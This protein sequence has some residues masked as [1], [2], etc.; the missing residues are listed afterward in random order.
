MA[1]IIFNGKTY[2]ALDE[3]STEE[4][5]AYEQIANMLVDKN[6]NGI[7]DF[8]E[9]DIIKNVTSFYNAASSINV[10]GN[11]YNN[12]DELPPD[13]QSKVQ[14]AFVKMADMGLV[15][16][17]SAMVHSAK[18]Q[19]QNEPYATSKPFVSREYNPTIEEDKPNPIIW[20]IMICAA[21]M[22][23]FAVAAVG[24]FFFLRS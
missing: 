6:G 20:W 17:D 3:M 12:L 13:V 9:G 22:L 24:I 23:C 21:F 15:S 10:N 11:V 8:L 7:P 1:T 5:Q 16:K 2:N 19:I 18:H 14:N 4:R